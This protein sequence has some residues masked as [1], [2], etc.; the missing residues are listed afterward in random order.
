MKFQVE[1]FLR[2]FDTILIMNGTIVIL[3]EWD[4]G[5]VDE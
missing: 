2:Y 5:R 1:Y 4:K 3:C